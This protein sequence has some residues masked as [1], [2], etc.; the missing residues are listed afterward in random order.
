MTVLRLA[1]DQFVLHGV[2]AECRVENSWAVV[3]SICDCSD[4]A[5]EQFECPCEGT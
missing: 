5:T 3:R 2:Y 1:F 4:R